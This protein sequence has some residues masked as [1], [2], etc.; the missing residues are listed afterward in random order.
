MPV[1]SFRHCRA[2]LA[3]SLAAVRR[4]LW[5]FDLPLPMSQI[6]AASQAAGIRAM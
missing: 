6:K 2:S 5:Q 3:R 4:L 1:T